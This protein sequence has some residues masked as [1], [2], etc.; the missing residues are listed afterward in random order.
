MKISSKSSNGR[1]LKSFE[2]GSGGLFC[3]KRENS[4]DPFRIDQSSLDNL[5]DPCDTFSE[6]EIAK[7]CTM[8]VRWVKDKI[9]SDPEFPIYKLFRRYYSTQESLSNYM[10]EHF[11][12]PGKWKPTKRQALKFGITWTDQS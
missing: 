2:C 4:K 7:Y 6:E 1:E 11:Q 12:T 5:S 10:R 3:E 8:S 9:K